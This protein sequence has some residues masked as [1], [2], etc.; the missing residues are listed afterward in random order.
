LRHGGIGVVDQIGQDLRDW[1]GSTS[2][3]GSVTW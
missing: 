3:T 2:H 1:S